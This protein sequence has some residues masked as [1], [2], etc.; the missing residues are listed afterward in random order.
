MA[1]GNVSADPSEHDLLMWGKLHKTLWYRIRA[2]MN[3]GPGNIPFP[4][5]CHWPE[6]TFLFVKKK[7]CQHSIRNYHP[8]SPSGDTS[9]ERTMGTQNNDL[10]KSYYILE[11]IDSWHG[12][13]MCNTNVI[14]HSRNASPVNAFKSSFYLLCPIKTSINSFPHSVSLYFSFLF[15]FL[16][17]LVLTLFSATCYS[18]KFLPERRHDLL[19]HFNEG[20][21]CNTCSFGLFQKKE[22]KHA[23]AN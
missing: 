14:L 15:I 11:H 16:S 20:S 22:H 6:E 7:S 21:L 1:S 19:C 2:L 5:S 10:L 23:R 13:Q 17:F 8:V 9:T 4:L 3:L 12:I 18:H